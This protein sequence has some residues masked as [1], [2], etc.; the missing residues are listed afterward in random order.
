MEKVNIKEQEKQARKNAILDAA[1][2]LFSEKDFHEVTVDEIA[3]HVGLSKGTLYLYF[4]NKEH[5]F[6]SIVKEKTELLLFRI[7]EAIQGNEPYLT[8]LERLIRSWLGFFEEHR[9]YFKILHSE[10]SRIRIGN[11]DLIRE[12]MMSSFRDY[13]MV[14][15]GFI[16]EGTKKHIFREMNPDVI[17]KGLRGLLNSFTFQCVFFDSEGD[18]KEETPVLLDLFLHGVNKVSE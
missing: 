17:V 3:D 6:L 10:K 11:Q 5:L 18:L 8:R 13:E 7:R 2:V 14:L 9:P 12:H 15:R 16:L 1:L 4:E